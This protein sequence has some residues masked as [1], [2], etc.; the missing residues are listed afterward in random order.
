MLVLDPAERGVAGAAARAVGILGVLAPELDHEILDDPVEVQPVIEAALG[1]LH[2]VARRDG[3]LVLKDLGGERAEGGLERRGRIR[4]W[5]GLSHRRRAVRGVRHVTGA[6]RQLVPSIASAIIATSFCASTLSM[7][8]LMNSCS[9]SCAASRRASGSPRAA[10]SRSS[11]VSVR[12][13]PPL[14]W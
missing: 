9:G 5:Q 11:Y 3:H 6:L 12:T 1:Q 8:A 10:A 2:E 14:R 4:H 7:L 13:L